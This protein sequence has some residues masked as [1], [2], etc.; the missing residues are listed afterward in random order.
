MSNDYKVGYK[1]PP[2]HTRFKPGQS[3]NKGGRPKKTEK[4]DNR[5]AFERVLATEVAVREAGKT[6]TMTIEEA[7]YRQLFAAG[8]KGST[9]DRKVLMSFIEKSGRLKGVTFDPGRE[10]GVLAV[11]MPLTEDEWE[12]RFAKPRPDSSTD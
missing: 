9:A 3:G 5:P 8:I 7:F 6:I 1:K 2:L 12:K 11:P 4:T 10:V